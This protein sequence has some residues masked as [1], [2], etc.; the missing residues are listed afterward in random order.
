M[1]RISS[2]LY[3]FLS[4]CFAMIFLGLLLMGMEMKSVFGWPL[5]DMVPVAMLAA[6]SIGLMTVVMVAGYR[7]EHR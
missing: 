6:G 5:A 3:W 1:K 4:A 2:E 7:I